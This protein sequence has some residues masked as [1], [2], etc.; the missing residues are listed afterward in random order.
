MTLMLLQVW[1]MNS[2]NG[3]VGV[4]NVQGSS[5]SRKKRQFHI[6]DPSPPTLHTQ[7]RPSDVN[8]FSQDSATADSYVLY[9]DLEGSLTLVTSDEGIHISLASGK[10]DIVTV[11]P[12]LSVAVG[13]KV[14]CVGLVNMLNAGGAVMD[15]KLGTARSGSVQCE[16]VVK[17]CGQLLLYATSA[18]S[19]VTSSDRV[20]EFEYAEKRKR[21]LIDLPEASELQTTILVEF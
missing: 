20:L 3:V 16:V 6:H 13:F 5:W 2:V 15:V 12:V 10:S 8:L 4:F 9:S 7:V 14:A 21:L 11:A 1:N 18:P 19:H 17:G